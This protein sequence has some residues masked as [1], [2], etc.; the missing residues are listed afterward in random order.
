MAGL[1]FSD[2]GDLVDAVFDDLDKDEVE[3]TQ[4]LAN[5]SAVRMLTEGAKTGGTPHRSNIRLRETD[6]VK[7]VKIM[8]TTANRRRDLNAKMTSEA[9]HTEEKIHYDMKEEAFISRDSQR[10]LDHIK[11]QRNGAIIAVMDLWERALATMPESADDTESVKG[12]LY[13]LR[14]ITAGQESWNGDFVG[15]N[16]YYGD[17]SASSMYQ[18]LDRSTA[19]HTRLRNFAINIGPDFDSGTIRALRLAR[20]E[21]NF[22]SLPGVTQNRRG[23]KVLFVGTDWLDKILD[24]NNT[25]RPTGAD[26]DVDALMEAKI[27]G[28][29]VVHCPALDEIAWAPMIGV[30]LSKVQ[31]KKIKDMWMKWTPAVNSREGLAIWTKGCMCSGYTHGVNPREAGFVAHTPIAA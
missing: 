21:T 16:V 2:I 7:W 12:L 3:Q 9:V 19:E 18:G 27:G 26:G 11:E 31:F 10:I 30:D 29:A 22:R 20:I 13:H 14:P 6:S 28:M 25:A 24:T 4:D 8:E 1:E 17:G 23:R 15:Q 5:Y